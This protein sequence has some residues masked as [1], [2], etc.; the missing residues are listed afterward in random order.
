MLVKGSQGLVAC[1]SK[2]LPS[3]SYVCGGVSG[4]GLGLYL[5]PLQ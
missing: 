5:F 4:M 2:G 3:L 1:D